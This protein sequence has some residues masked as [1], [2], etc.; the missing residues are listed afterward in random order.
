MLRSRSVWPPAGFEWT[1]AYAQP[2]PIGDRAVVTF[3]QK[4]RSV[5]PSKWANAVASAELSVGRI[6]SRTELVVSIA[7]ELVVVVD[8]VSPR[9]FCERQE[10]VRGVVDASGPYVRS[11]EPVR[12]ADGRQLVAVQ[13]HLLQQG[14]T[15]VW[16]RCGKQGWDG[17]TPPPCHTVPAFRKKTV[18]C[19][20]VGK[21]DGRWTL[22]CGRDADP[23][24]IPVYGTA[25]VG[26]LTA[27]IGTRVTFSYWGAGDDGRL[28]YP[29]FY[30]RGSSCRFKS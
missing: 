12:I 30:H 5:S 9:S 2:V 4:T 13:A 1:H 28:V 18:P 20:D 14:W 3:D 11:A 26:T 23:L 24:T 29:V 17:A 6:S 25:D 8:V 22:I 7:P 15:G 21:A 27:Y 10:I 19:L 16:L